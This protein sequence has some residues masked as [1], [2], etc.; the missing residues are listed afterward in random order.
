MKKLILGFCALP[1]LLAPLGDGGAALATEVD[2]L[3]EKLVEKGVLSRE[4]ADALIEEAREETAEPA[5]APEEKAV[6][7][8]AAAPEEPAEEETAKASFTLPKWVSRIHPF[9][10]LR[11]RHDTQWID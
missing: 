1:L 10:D 6:P 8:V 2:T 3:V 11:L 9:A 5:V 7:D 4:E